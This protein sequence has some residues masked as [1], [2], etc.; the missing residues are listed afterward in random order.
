MLDEIEYSIMSK[1]ELERLLYIESI[2]ADNEFAENGD[3]ILFRKIERKID[4]IRKKLDAK[5][6]MSLLYDDE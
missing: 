3:T 2:K 1:D 5:W 6:R 4:L